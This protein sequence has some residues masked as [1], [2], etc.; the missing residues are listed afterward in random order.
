MAAI[1]VDEGASIDYTS[2]VDRSV[3]EVVSVVTPEGDGFIGVVPC[4]IKAG[5]KGALAVAGVFELPK[6]D[7]NLI[8]GQKA[9]WDA[10]QQKIVTSPTLLGCAGNPVLNGRFLAGSANWVNWTERGSASRDFNSS[11]VPTN[12]RAPALRIWQTGNFNGGVYQA[13]TVTPGQAYTLRILSRDLASTVDAAWVEVLIGTPVPVNGQD[14]AGG[15]G[16]RQLL[17]KWDTYVCPRWNG[18]QRTAGV[19]QSLTFTATAATM[20]LVL[21]AGQNTS[22][23]A[24]VDV[25]FDDVALCQ[26]P[27]EPAIFS[28]IGVVIANAS[29]ADKTA[30]VRLSQ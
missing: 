3:G 25:S 16:G 27:S 22:P 14:Y 28:P 13:V 29:S 1:F 20:Y 21:K 18:D 11:L 19:V 23:T 12:G 7:E 15:S 24:V 2:P 30:L 8:A 5:S 4:A 9:Y 6:A 10:L 17:A 26:A